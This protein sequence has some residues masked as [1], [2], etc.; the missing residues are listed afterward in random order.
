MLT[1]SSTMAAVIPK[2]RTVYDDNLG[3]IRMDSVGFND[4]QPMDLNEFHQRLI[5]I[6]DDMGADEFEALKFLC[7]DHMAGL[8]EDIYDEY[9]LL[10]YRHV[11]DQN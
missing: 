8:Y 10:V 6:D 4:P 7:R 5:N 2:G 3:D 1:E 11:Y 9:H